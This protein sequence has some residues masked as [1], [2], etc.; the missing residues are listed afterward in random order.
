MEDL[1]RTSQPFLQYLDGWLKN[2]PVVPLSAE[3]PQPERTAVICVD[4]VNGFCNEGALASPRVKAI[5]EPVGQLLQAAWNA[6]VRNMV[7]SQDAH[8]PDALEFQAFAPHCVQGTTEAETIDEI[9]SL[10]FYNRMVLL[11]KNSIHSGFNTGL[12]EWMDR[13]PHLDTFLVVGDCTDLCIYQLAMALKLEANSQQ[14]QRRVI[15]AADCVQTYDLPVE[16]AAQVPALPH[17]GDFFHAVF[18]YHMALNGI[19]VVKSIRS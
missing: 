9:K 11:E 5:V 14:K 16:V 3:I 1:V 4:L 15:L 6:G 2:L 12:M 17:D 7:L 19:E 13:N 8:E 10:P 18:L